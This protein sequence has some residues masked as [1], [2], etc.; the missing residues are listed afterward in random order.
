M[1]SIYRLNSNE[2]NQDILDAIQKVFHDKEIEIIIHDMEDETEYLLK[3]ENNREKL[4]SAIQD[5]RE[6]KELIP[7]N[8]KNVDSVS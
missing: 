4:L 6:N 3:S 2:L 5:I 8:M 1:L 7:F